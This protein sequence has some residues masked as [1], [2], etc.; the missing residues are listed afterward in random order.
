MKN[1]D[2][3]IYILDRFIT[4]IEET[5]QEHDQVVLNKQDLIKLSE[6]F[7]F[8]KNSLDGYINKINN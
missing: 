3:I 8:M 5:I 6:I 4:S 7:M 1:I 2:I